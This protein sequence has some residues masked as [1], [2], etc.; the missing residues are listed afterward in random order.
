M[1]Q[2]DLY[3]C[4]LF[5][6]VLP[7][8][9]LWVLPEHEYLQCW[10]SRLAYC[11]IAYSNGGLCVPV[12]KDTLNIAVLPTFIFGCFVC[13]YLSSLSCDGIGP[14][15]KICL[16][17]TP[18][19]KRGIT[20]SIIRITWIQLY[21]YEIV[22]LC[23]SWVLSLPCKQMGMRAREPVRPWFINRFNLWGFVSLPLN[24]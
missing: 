10:H 15:L 21:W 19:T 11:I 8:M 13:L 12:L 4:I 7:I 18:L 2:G 1:E 3:L 17:N 24:S 16:I 6:K 23:V 5:L 20:V 14:S 22:S 9:K